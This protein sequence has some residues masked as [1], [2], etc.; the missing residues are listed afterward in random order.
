MCIDNYLEQN[1]L[2]AP[3][4]RKRLSEWIRKQDSY[5]CCLQETHF[6]SGDTSS[7]K[8][9]GL[10]KILHA[11]GNQK[12]TGIAISLPDK[13]VFKIKNITEDPRRGHNY[14]RINPRRYNNCKYIYICTQRRNTSIYKITV[15][16]HKRRNQQ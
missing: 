13:I 7:L 11:N 2:N 4:K 9:R 3:T 12:K 6:S 14:Q 16:S 8:V 15:N 5:I 1:G 10:K